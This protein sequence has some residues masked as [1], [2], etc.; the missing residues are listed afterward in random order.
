MGSF[1][2]IGF[3]SLYG[4]AGAELYHQVKVRDTW[5]RICILYPRKKT[6]TGPGFI[7]KCL[8]RVLRG[9]E[10]NSSIG[11][12]SVAENKGQS[13]FFLSILG[14]IYGEYWSCKKQ[15]QYTY[16]KY[17]YDQECFNNFMSSSIS[18]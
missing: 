4:G 7:W 2:I 15:F 17:T 9:G 14:F 10:A 18:C 6:F 12:S 13:K 5:M 3:P 1:Y 8:S 16:D 11:A